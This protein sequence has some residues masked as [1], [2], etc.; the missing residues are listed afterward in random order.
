MAKQSAVF[1]ILVLI[2]SPLFF[3][4]RFLFPAK[5]K[6]DKYKLNIHGIHTPLK[7]VQI[8]DIHYDFPHAPQRVTDSLLTS[9]VSTINSLKPDLIVL[10]GDY[11]QHDPVP[12]ENLCKLHL[13]KLK[14]RFGV[15]ATLG[16]H[17]LHF[18]TS[19]EIIS[20][21]FKKY[22]IRFLDNECVLPFPKEVGKFMVVGLGDLHMKDF[23]PEKVEKELKDDTFPKLLLS[24]NPDT[25]K[26]LM[27]YSI[28]LQVSGHTHGSG[29][30][31][32]FIGPVLPHIHTILSWFPKFIIKDVSKIGYVN[33]IKNWKW[34]SGLHTVTSHSCYRDEKKVEV[35]NVLYVNRGLATHPPL[36]LF[37]DPEITL[38]EL[39]PAEKK[40]QVLKKKKKKKK[41]KKSTLR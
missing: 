16:N 9:V 6:V 29:I 12:V 28:D 26:M 10:T 32:P 33:V 2:L 13:S 37:C 24:H 35:N 18:A 41:K 40:G 25:A 30:V 14:S 3:I 39:Y 8:S 34:L 1:K 4:L 15:F 22:G 27:Q 11:V 20:T 23:H 17:D 19:K 5:L 31:L 38:L 7:V 21:A 36:R